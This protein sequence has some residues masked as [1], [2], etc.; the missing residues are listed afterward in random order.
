MNQSF[1]IVIGAFTGDQCIQFDFKLF[2]GRLIKGK[3]HFLF[4]F[5]SEEM[6][7]KE[8]TFTAKMFPEGL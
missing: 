7:R 3:H 4:K 1:S 6:E 8:E 5:N 2:L